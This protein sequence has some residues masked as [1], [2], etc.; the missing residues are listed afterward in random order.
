[1]AEYNH[2]EIMREEIVQQYKFQSYPNAPRPPIRDKGQH[3]EKLK[4]Q[5]ETSLEKIVSKRRDIGI[6]SENLV[7]LELMSDALSSE[8]LE[9]MLRKFNMYLVEETDIPE[10]NNSKLVVQFENLS[11][12]QLFNQE[13][14]LWKNDDRTEAI[15]TYAK[16]RDIFSCI[17]NIRTV[18]RE[19]RI[20]VRLKKYFQT[21]SLMP[22]GLFIVNIDVWFNGEQTTVIEVE[23]QI[24]QALGTEGSK[25]LCDLFQIPSMLLGKA[26]VNEFTL[27]ALLDMDIVAMVDL[28]FSNVSPEPYGL[29]NW[30]YEPVIQDDLE[31]DAP[32]AAV[33]DSGI[34]TGNPLLENVVVA[35]EEFDTTENTTTDMNGHG[36]GVAGI[37]VYGD[38]TN[39]IETGNFKPLVRVCNGKIMHDEEGNPCFPD[40]IRPEQI[41]REA[42]EY[43]NKEFG[44][45]VFNLS[46][47]DR[48]YLYSGGRQFAW[49]EML[50]QL[51]R[52][53]DV[54][55][56]ISAGNVSAPKLKEFS[57]REELMNQSRNQL[58]MPEHRL[59]DPATSALGITV[60]SITRFDEP[61]VVPNRITSVAAGKKDHLSVFTRI[62]KGVNGAIKPDVVDYGGNYAVSQLMRSRNR[63][64]TNDLGLLEPTLNN[65]NDKIFRGYC[66]TSFSAPHVTHIVARIERALEKQLQEKP[67][68]NLIRAI[69]INSAR[70]T[71]DMVEWADKSEDS[72]YTGKSNP[73]Q[74]RKLRLYGYGRADDSLLYSDYNRVTLFTED[75]LSLR[76]FHLYKIPV[77]KDF[78][79]IKAN[80]VI[81]ISLAFNP[82]TRLSR[83]DYLTN[84]LW[85]EVFRRIDEETLVLYKAKKKSGED[86]ED[87]LDKL[88][89]ENKAKDFK[90]GYTEIN[91]GTLQQRI[92]QKSARGGSD[93]LWDENEP[94]IYILVTGKERFKYAEQEIPQEYALAITFSYE[95]EEDIKLYTKLKNQVRVKIRQRERERVRDRIR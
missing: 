80:K 87:D 35:E 57:S 36:T 3:G 72:L 61:S 42:I 38:F 37:V 22:D 74:E 43:F 78:L 66:G 25:L 55:I 81:S 28:P 10:S 75:K 63:W 51:A 44:C 59:I 9:H 76:S 1:M 90:P 91:K 31:D 68:A 23:R 26:L 21:P 47:G 33:L 60:G 83:K 88:P 94:Y 34:F 32:L 93:L 18:I 15:L 4:E 67:S 73:K 8:L 29:Y 40:D 64:V 52:E 82:I 77:P 58:F 16:R 7:V 79:Q 49:A 30:D 19:D 17:D 13:R 92:W 46:V 50:D 5:L 41:V 56:I 71:D 45:R 11:D 20:G 84:N 48:E 95:S 86:E 53:L 54:V 27:N 85:F 70:Y 2:I 62:G 69:F 24:K 12:I 39:S 6:Q 89:D 65:T 14:E